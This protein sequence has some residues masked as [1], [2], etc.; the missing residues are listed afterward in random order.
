MTSRYGG[1]IETVPN[2]MSIH[3][4]KKNAYAAKLNKPGAEFTLLDH[5][6]FVRRGARA[7]CGQTRTGDDA[8]HRELTV[9][10]RL[11]RVG[12]GA[13]GFRCAHLPQEFGPPASPRHMR[14]R[15]R[16][17]ESLAG[18]SLAC[19][20]L[21]VKDRHGF[22]HRCGHCLRGA[23][24]EQDD[25]ADPTRGRAGWVSAWSGWEGRHDGNILLDREGHVIH[26]DYGFILSSSPG[27]VGFET[28]PFK[29]RR[30][31]HDRAVCDRLHRG[32]MRV[33]GAQAH[34]RSRAHGQLSDE[35]IAVLGGPD[36]RTCR[37]FEDLFLAGFRAL[38]KHVDE[39]V[40][41]LEI[42]QQR[43]WRSGA[44]RSLGTSPTRLRRAHMSASSE[45]ARTAVP[46]PSR[47][48]RLQHGLLCPRSRGGDGVPRALPAA[49]RGGPGRGLCGR[50]RCV[51]RRQCLHDTL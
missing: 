43:M 9:D 41:V 24:H 2:A 40:V 22:R 33:V 48:H 12:G 27:G 23:P 19:Y 7:H 35:Y 36:S 17:A 32:L 11:D 49:P 10:R 47:A 45:R 18:Y 8:G 4:I 30:D 20:L 21:Q 25:A 28:A 13:S 42:M 16:F 6:C 44:R 46:P 5:F 38:R 14:A 3:S 31:D 26:I 34:R 39:L 37:R 51:R 29:V 15:E 50:P 1:I